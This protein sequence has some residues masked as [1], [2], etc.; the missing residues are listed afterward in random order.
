MSRERVAL[1]GRS[2]DVVLEQG[3]SGLSDALSRWP[4]AVL[5]TESTVGPL[6]AAAVQR[7]LGLSDEP[8]VLPAG[9]EHKTV[10]TWSLAVDGLLSRRVD[11]R[12]VVLALGGGVLGDIAGFAAA[13]TLRG[14][15]VVQLP[16]TL[17]S[18]VD[19]SV[20][21]KTAVNH[22]AGK[23][24]VGAFHQPS[25]V[26]AALDTL[27]TLSVEE[28]R[29]GLGEVLKTAL[30]A[31][32]E[33][34]ELVREKAEALADGER[35]ATQR[36]VQLCV[37]SKAHVVAQD[38]R[39]GG[40]RAILNAGHTAGH[41]IEASL[42]YG[43]LRHGEAVALGLVAEARHAANLGLCAY[44]LADQL[45]ALTGRLGLPT[46]TPDFSSEVAQK[47]VVMDKKALGDKVR[48]PLPTAPGHVILVDQDHA[49]LAAMLG[50]LP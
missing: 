8:L 15:D 31:G 3:F 9:E 17:L 20:G 24:L 7:E 33:L 10:A 37:R 27:D 12:T 14:L 44:E 48:V 42:G 50:E 40:L 39:E 29:A 34:W 22:A 49:A 2:Y 25:L 41:A 35:E 30:I 5:V 19:S 16:T 6:W 28:R 1:G 46:S 45:R 18:M 4:R 38:E 43:A 32:G 23:N 13:S 47:A 11:R 36:A 21:G 26:W